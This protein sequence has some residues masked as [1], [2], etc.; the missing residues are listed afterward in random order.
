MTA[1]LRAAMPEETANLQAAFLFGSAINAIAAPRD[2]D[3]VLVTK[4]AA[5]ENG[6]HTIRKWR[7]RL[8]KDFIEQFNLPLSAMVVTPSE[9]A[10]I[11]GVVVRGREALI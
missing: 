9:W 6:W 7:D 10:E 2:I 5:G 11:D 3:I 8:A 1:W 4:A